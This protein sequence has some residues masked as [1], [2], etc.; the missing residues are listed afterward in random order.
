[1]TVLEKFQIILTFKIKQLRYIDDK[2]IFDDER[3]FAEAFGRGGL[4]EERK[5]RENYKQEKKDE[6]IKRIK[7]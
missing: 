5:D 2:P 7:E 1:M 4:E 6:Q 3:R